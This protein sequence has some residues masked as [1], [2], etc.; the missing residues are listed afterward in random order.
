MDV[1]L[2]PITDDEFPAYAR[3]I[4]AA[5]AGTQTDEDTADWRLVTELDRTIAGFD[6]DQIVATAGAF[7][8]ELTL[9]GPT[10]VPVAGV[11]A[12]T[13]LPT[14]R[15]RG[16]LTAMMDRQLDDVAQRGEPIAILTASES[17]IYGRFGYGMAA[18]TRGWSLDT[19]HARHIRPPLA[20][21][22]LR[23]IEKDEAQALVPPLFDRVR[24]GIPGAVSRP[25]NWPAQWFKDRESDREGASGRFYVVH[26]PDGGG[27]PDGYAAYRM[28]R[29]WPHGLASFELRAEDVLAVDDEVEAALWQFLSEVDLV[30]TVKTHGRPVD[31]PLQWRLAD[32]R[33]LAT[34]GLRDHLWLRILDVPV[35][36]G[37]RRYA[38][39]DKLV[40]ELTDPFRP[41]NDGRWVVEGGP[42]GAVAG[43][44][45]AEPDLALDVRELA[46]LYLGG[47]TATTLGRAG[48]VEERRAGALRRADAFFATPTA[49]WCYT[50]F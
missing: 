8:M 9:P 5:F 43:R 11:T 22:S 10:T 31:E 36:L 38:T 47:V 2:R 29:A 18:S 1:E 28:V 50:D 33:R 3:V 26:E 21:G 34:D 20:G 42:V 19:R 12:V 32:P 14:H 13:V 25:R 24:L 48:R 49:P 27:D 6:R 37:A 44:T 23:M 45:S 40:V 30:A 15:R 39:E 7:S 16:L 41:A 35:A 17:L 4:G 46:A